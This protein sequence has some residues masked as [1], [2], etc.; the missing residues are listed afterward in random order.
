MV[1]DT[2][3]ATGYLDLAMLHRDAAQCLPFYSVVRA[4]H[5]RQAEYLESIGAGWLPLTKTIHPES[6]RREALL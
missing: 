6:L 3:I 5:V 1:S 2:K 4:K